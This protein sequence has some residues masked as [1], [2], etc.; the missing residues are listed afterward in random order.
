MPMLRFLLIS[1]EMTPMLSATLIFSPG[2]RSQPAIDAAA[3][4]YVAAAA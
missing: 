2:V 1:I 4:D 3:D